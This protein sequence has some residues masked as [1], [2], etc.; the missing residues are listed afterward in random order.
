MALVRLSPI[1]TASC[2]FFAI[3]LF[4]SVRQHY[5]GGLDSAV[6][7]L[8]Q[9]YGHRPDAASSGASWTHVIWQSSKY[10]AENQTDQD[11]ALS[12]TWA[13]KNPSHRH[14]MMTHERMI[15]YTN[16]KFS[17][18]APELQYLYD[19]TIDY[20]MRTDVLRYLVLWQD[21][22]VYNDL[23]VECLEPID[24]WVPDEFKDKAGV[25]VGIEND[26]AK[27]SKS[28]VLG[29]VVWT[30]LAKPNQPF[31]RF[32]LDRLQEN[33]ANV[34]AE[35]QASVNTH[36][37]MDITGPAATSVSFMKYASK[38]TGTEV[39]YLNFTGMT[40]PKMIGEVLV[41]PIWSFGAEH[42]VTK[43]GFKKDQGKPL[44]KHHFA[45]TWKADHGDSG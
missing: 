30:M 19:E 20:M 22:G 25:V 44:V 1:L 27:D 35:K 7:Y 37:L 16:D 32:V 4:A 28:H 17:A 31:I 34:S 29:L 36:E 3:V 5:R 45:G 26:F 14:L 39:S 11:R 23:D 9:G 12:R 40:E 8:T 24:M 15:G 2:M 18:S 33:L 38:V 41:L 10:P 21:G 6:K 42:Q 43:A 13:E